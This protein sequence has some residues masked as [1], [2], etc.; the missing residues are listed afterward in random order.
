MGG[1]S[2]PSGWQVTR[3]SNVILLDTQVLLWL[4]SGDRRLGS[5]SRQTIDRELRAG[6][7]A[8]SAIS[9]WEV[10]MLKRKGRINFTED[11]ATW[12]MS[13]LEEGLLE[14]PL[15]GQIGIRAAELAEL[16]A[17]PADRIIVATALEGHQLVTADDRI[18]RWS[19]QLSRL[20]ART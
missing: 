3:Y 16:H 20:D 5:K 14:V 2:G 4:R 12:R 7:V 18:L 6:Q 10:A 9:F 13:Q 11:V 19:G 15:T 1:R 17:D 8:V